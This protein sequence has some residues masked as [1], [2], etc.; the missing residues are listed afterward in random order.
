M[1]RTDGRCIVDRARRRVEVHPM[2]EV[3][4]LAPGGWPAFARAH[5]HEPWDIYFPGKGERVEREKRSRR[6]SL[7]KA[8]KTAR[9]AGVDKGTVTVGDVSVTLGESESTEA[10][11][12]WLADL[13]KVTKQ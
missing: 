2:E 3:L 7:A 13:N 6:P 8:I 10:A 5:G 11:N 1:N 9:K 4:G 12:P